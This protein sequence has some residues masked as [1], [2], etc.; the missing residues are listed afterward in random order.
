MTLF[1]LSGR[2]ALVSGCGSAQGIGAAIAR[3]LLGQGAAVVVTATGPWIHERVEELAAHGTV[4]GAEADLTDPGAPAGLLALAERRFGP[5]DTLVNNAGMTQRG[6]PIAAADFAGVDLDDWHASIARTLTTAVH[7]TRATLP[8]ML[9]HGFGRVIHVSSVTGP[10]VANTGDAAYATAKAGLDGHMRALALECGP[11]GVTVNSVA[12]GWID[13][14]SAS[15]AERRAG[16]HTP[17]GRS[18]RPDEVAATVAFL[19][20]REA[21]YVTGQ[22]LVV[23]GGNIVQEVKGS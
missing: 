23:D 14:A 22:S 21:S 17:V 13:T 16:R 19:A 9:E 8:G 3:A 4:A 15:D 20:S 11:R 12:P 5:V 18:G 2:V 1:D 7:L 10:Y 6:R